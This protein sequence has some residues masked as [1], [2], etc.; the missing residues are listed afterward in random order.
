MNFVNRMAGRLMGTALL[1]LTLCYAHHSLAQTNARQPAKE[2]NDQDARPPVTKVDIEIAKRARAL[3][4]SE[5]SWDRADR[6]HITDDPTTKCQPAAKQ[7]SLYCALERATMEVSGKFEH[8]GA[9]MQEARFVIEG[10]EPDWEKKY[11][12]LLVDYNNDP[13]T[14]FQDIQNVLRSIEQRIAGRLKD[15]T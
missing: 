3:L 1:A 13:H 15:K 8:R 9:V 10:V 2:S 12:H 7:M 6:P 14:T 11:H 5:S 4:R